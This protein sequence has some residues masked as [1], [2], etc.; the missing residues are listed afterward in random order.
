MDPLSDVLD[1]SRVRA[2][3]LGNVHAGAPWGLGLPRSEGASLHAVTCGT[4]WLRVQGAD[5]RQLMP[6][7]VLLLPSGSEHRLSSGPATRCD[8]FDR[9]MKERRMSAEGDLTIGA[10]GAET[11]FVCAG[12]D[13]D[14]DV[15]HPLMSLLPPVMHIPADPVGG[16][17]LAALVELLAAEVDVRGP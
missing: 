16:R 12:Y 13:Y 11:A 1:L 2:A 8:T 7:D 17:K 4:A 5:A 15:A 6:G 9:D 14:L 10:R 3:L